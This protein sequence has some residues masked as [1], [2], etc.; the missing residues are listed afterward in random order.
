[1]FAPPQRL[2]G[3]HAHVPSGYVHD[4]VPVQVPVAAA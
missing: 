3:P 2:G 4:A 1:M